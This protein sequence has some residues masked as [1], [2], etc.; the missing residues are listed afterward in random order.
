MVPPSIM[1]DRHL[2][3]EHVELHMLV[4]ALRRKV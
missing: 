1:C 2:L 3:G 4:G